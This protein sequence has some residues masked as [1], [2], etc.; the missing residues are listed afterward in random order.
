MTDAVAISIVTSVSAVLVSGLS[1]YFAYK[2]KVTSKETHDV[3]NSRMEAFLKMAEKSFKAEGKL[4]GV[5]EQKAK[6]A[7]GSD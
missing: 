6:Y 5:A 2:A 7:E 3:V 1:A 4:E